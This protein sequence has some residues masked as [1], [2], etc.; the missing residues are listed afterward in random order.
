MGVKRGTYESMCKN[1]PFSLCMFAI[2]GQ[3][4]YIYTIYE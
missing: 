2:P 4:V 3:L 1:E